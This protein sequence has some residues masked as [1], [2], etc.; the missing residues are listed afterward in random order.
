VRQLAPGETV[1]KCRFQ[2]KRTQIFWVCREIPIQ[3]KYLIVFELKSA[4]N[5]TLPLGYRWHLSLGCC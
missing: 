5:D 2:C 4:L 1:S 3:P